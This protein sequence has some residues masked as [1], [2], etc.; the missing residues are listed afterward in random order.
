MSPISNCHF[1]RKTK[2]KEAT[3]DRTMETQ[4]WGAE[5]IGY[6]VMWFR[7]LGYTYYHGLKDMITAMCTTKIGHIFV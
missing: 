7:V 1:L 6:Q 4:L 5:K 2:K 3:V